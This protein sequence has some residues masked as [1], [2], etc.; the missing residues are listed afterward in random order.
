MRRCAH[1]YS[2]DGIVA[3]YKV[4][5]DA[6]KLTECHLL[7]RNSKILRFCLMKVWDNSPIKGKTII[8]L[9]ILFKINH[10]DIFPNRG[11]H[12]QNDIRKSSKYFLKQIWNIFVKKARLIHSLS[13]F[14]FLLPSPL[15]MMAIF[16][17]IRFFTNSISA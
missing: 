6:L 5:S 16:L 9:F 17:R 13:I 15:Q 2:C 10:Y 4:N 8:R 1:I 11:W 12:S 14:S 3:S 7:L